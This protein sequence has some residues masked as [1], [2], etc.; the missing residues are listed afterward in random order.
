MFNRFHCLIAIRSDTD[1]GQNIT[2]LE[3]HCKEKHLT[4]TVSHLNATAP[5]VVKWWLH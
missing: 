1:K 4:Q 3:H 2:R 5:H